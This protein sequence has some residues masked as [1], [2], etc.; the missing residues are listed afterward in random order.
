ML[1][2][3]SPFCATG[4]MAAEAAETVD[5]RNDEPVEETVEDQAPYIL[6]TEE[7]EETS[8]NEPIVQLE[9]LGKTEG[10]IIEEKIAV[11]PHFV[12]NGEEGSR[13][14]LENTTEIAEPTDDG[15]Y[16]EELY[17]GEQV[18]YLGE[19]EFGMAKILTDRGE[20]YINTSYLTEDKDQI[21]FADERT[22]WVLTDTE[23]YN[24][25]KGEEPIANLSK[26]AELS[27]TG[28]N[29]SDF[30]RISLDGSDAFVQK[31]Y[32]T[33]YGVP[34]EAYMSYERDEVTEYNE[35]GITEGILAEVTP[36]N[37]SDEDVMYLAR[38]IKCEAGG[39]TME[40]KRAV[41]TVIVNRLFNGHW[42]NTLSSVVEA[43][44]QFEPVSSGKFAVAVPSESDIEA[45]RQV[46]LEGYRSFPAYVMYF[47]S[48]EDGYF[49]GH[50]TYLT[51]HDANMR[52]SQYFSFRLADQAKY[53]VNDSY[54]E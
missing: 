47:Q 8:G 25:Y 19:N 34:G 3:I 41:G 26:G 1:F 36:E 17:E 52:S 31:Q 29:D 39:Q 4:V 13:W 49:S 12:F 2:S 22:V 38:I 20:V 7:M 33:S 50:V 30:L 53:S 46:L 9:E 45:A 24:D 15:A 32:L 5:Y 6:E 16:G 51:S 42:G 21:F 28:S 54:V 37:Q 23:A 43:P 11:D 18:Y 14:V 35:E 40:G 44:G 27:V 10:V 48:I